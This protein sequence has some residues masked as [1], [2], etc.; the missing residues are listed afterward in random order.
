MSRQPVKGGINGQT[1][2]G[3]WVGGFKTLNKKPR[4]DTLGD[5]IRSAGCK[6]RGVRLWGAT[7]QS[8][9]S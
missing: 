3:N 1:T 4:G 7:H 8:K 2:I 9:G 5:R 6:A